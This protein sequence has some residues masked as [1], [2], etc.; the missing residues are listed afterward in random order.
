MPSLLYQEPSLAAVYD[1]FNAWGADNDFYL[2][3]LKP[4]VNT[5]LDIGC[6][7]GLLAVA[8]AKQAQVTGLEPAA[9]MLDIARQ[10]P[11]GERVRWL[12]TDA[13]DFALDERFD[14]IYCTGHA[15][16]VFLTEADRQALW[17]NVKAHLAREGEFVFETRNPW[18]RP[19][20]QWGERPPRRVSHAEWGEVEISHLIRSVDGDRVEFQAR[21]RFLDSGQ[22]FEI[23]EQL[24]F[25]DLPTLQAEAASAGLRVD[26]VYGDWQQGEWREDSPEI[27]LRLR[28][29]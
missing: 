1:L 27:I 25:C 14:L 4:V 29:G 13:R 2:G 3:L 18:P 22:V 24:C 5:V 11:G 9:A 21:Y 23:E 26:A 8:M 7:T 12:Q 28:H 15:F 19:W 6:G 20:E 16:Q 10:R 17:R